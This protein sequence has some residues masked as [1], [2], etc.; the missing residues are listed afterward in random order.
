MYLDV[1]AGN[2]FISGIYETRDHRH[3]VPSAVYVDLVYQWSTFLGCGV[4]ATDVAAAIKT[5]DAAGQSYQLRLFS[6]ILIGTYCNRPRSRCWEGGP[7]LC[8]RPIRGK[9]A[10]NISRSSYERYTSRSLSKGDIG[11][12]KTSLTFA[13]TT[14]RGPKSRMCNARNRRSQRRTY[15]CRARCYGPTNHVYSWI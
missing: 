5:W 6:S 11:T 15:T 1:V 3:V 9:L 14:S 12:T 7:P 2:P 10:R 4:N 8:Y 13:A